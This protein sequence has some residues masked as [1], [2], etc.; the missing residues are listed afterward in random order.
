[1]A[2]AA[3][4]G[5]VEYL[6]VPFKADILSSQGAGTAAEQLQALINDQ[7]LRGYRYVRMETLR[8]RITTPANAGCFGIGSTPELVS[9]TDI[10]AVV[11]TKK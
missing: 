1:M 5:A 9:Y 11:F 4:A 8:T 7:S 6:V 10:Y 3:S 2:T